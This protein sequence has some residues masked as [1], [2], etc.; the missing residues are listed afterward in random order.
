MAFPNLQPTTPLKG[1]SMKLI[2]TI[3]STLR[4]FVT[5]AAAAFGIQSKPALG[6]EST[7]CINA[8]LLNLCEGDADRALWVLRWLA[9]PLRNE[10]AKMATALL[11]GGIEGSGKSLFFNKVIAGLYGDRAATPGVHWDSA[12]NEWMSAR[13]YVLID[14][15]RS[16]TDNQARIKTLLTSDRIK[17]NR[18]AADSK[19]E[20]NKMNFVFL[21]SH[22]DAQSTADGD[23]RFM[24]L[25]PQVKM[26]SAAYAGVVEEIA[27]GGIEEF[28][29]FLVTHLEMD[30]FCTRSLPIRK[31]PSAKEAA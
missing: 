15:L 4:R 1:I 2:T 10:G 23:R 19:I 30:G 6:P 12:F 3:K 27:S 21:T 17:I 28:H 13:R 22:R 20:R 29:H 31:A 25:E 9:Y 7:P 16:L 14:E 5:T 11:V 8:L 24:V 18:I 26:P